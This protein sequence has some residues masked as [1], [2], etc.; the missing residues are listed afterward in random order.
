MLKSSNI[1]ILERLPNVHTQTSRFDITPFL[2]RI[3]RPENWRPDNREIAEI[4]EI[5]LR[6]LAKPEAHGEEIKNFPEWPAPRLV[7]F[8]RVGN[9]QLWGATYRI[10]NPI[11]DKLLNGIW[12]I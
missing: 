12:K 8:Y 5:P 3:V 11:V 1:H 2:A 7:P 10:L 6:D 4:I 9:Y